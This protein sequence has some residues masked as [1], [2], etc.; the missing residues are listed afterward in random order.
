MSDALAVIGM[1]IA[2]LICQF[3]LGVGRLTSHRALQPR[4]FTALWRSDM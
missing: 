2:G 4:S 1:L 3:D